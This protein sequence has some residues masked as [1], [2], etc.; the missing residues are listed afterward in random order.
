MVVA[1]GVMEIDGIHNLNIIV[2][3]LKTRGLA[4]EDIEGDKVRFQIERETIE[5]V[6]TEMDSIRHLHE[7]R[8]LHIT[9]YSLEDTG[10]SQAFEVE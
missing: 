7:V 4:I 2:S 6:K 9:Y 10:N 5:E 3:E 8:N 1:S